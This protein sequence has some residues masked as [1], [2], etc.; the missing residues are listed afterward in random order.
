MV[1]FRQHRS[2]EYKILAR[3]GDRQPMH[4]KTAGFHSIHG[5]LA[6]LDQRKARKL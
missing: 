3:T 2:S 5:A 6:I 1:S 4:D